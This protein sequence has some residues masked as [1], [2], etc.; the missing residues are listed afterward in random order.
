MRNF[1]TLTSTAALESL[2]L[3][4]QPIRD[5][6]NWLHPQDDCGDRFP[7]VAT[8]SSSLLAPEVRK[9]HLM[10]YGLPSLPERELVGYLKSQ[11]V[12]VTCASH[13][14]A[15]KMAVWLLENADQVCLVDSA[16]R[17]PE[18]LKRWHR[19]LSANARER[20]TFLFGNMADEDWLCRA[21]A[22]KRPSVVFDFTTHA[23]LRAHVPVR[24]QIAAKEAR[25]Y[26]YVYDKAEVITNIIR[27]SASLGTVGTLFLVMPRFEERETAD[28]F[29]RLCSIVL[30]DYTVAVGA[31]VSPQEP[32]ISVW[33]PLQRALPIRLPLQRLRPALAG[34]TSDDE[35]LN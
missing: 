10:Q 12:F 22:S 20:V 14:I 29:E 21:M 33:A 35:S 34:S 25:R 4:F 7:T 6:F 15:A 30:R 24:L 31:H 32:T 13:P 16:R 2:H 23:Y 9:H 26:Q 17:K 27:C 3:Y 1:A 28:H 18:V 8:R 5:L 11:T 19:A